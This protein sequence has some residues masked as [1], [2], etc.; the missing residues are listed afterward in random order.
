MLNHR[1]LKGIFRYYEFIAPVIPLDQ[2]IYL[3]EGHTPLVE[4]N[5]RLK[6]KLG[7]RL[8]NPEAHAFKRFLAAY[9]QA[10][11][12]SLYGADS[13]RL[14]KS[15]FAVVV[16]GRLSTDNPVV[17]FNLANMMVTNKGA[18]L[19]FHPTGDRHM[20]GLHKNIL[21][22]RHDAG[23]EEAVLY[24]ILD[25]FADR[26]A[27]PEETARYLD[28]Y[29]ATKQESIEETITESV[30]KED[31]TEE[32]VQKKITKEVEVKLSRLC[33]EFGV[34]FTRETRESIDKLLA[35]KETYTLVAGSDLFA[36]PRWENIAHLLGMIARL[37]PFEVLLLPDSV[38]TLGTAL[39]CDLD[40]EPTGSVA[41]YNA[42]GDFTLSALGGGDLDMPALNQQEGTV[43]SLD[44]RVVP[45]AP[46]LGYE[47]YTLGELADA[48]GVPV[49]WTVD[50]TVELPIDRGF[51]PVAFDTL[52]NHFGPDGENHRGY[53]LEEREGTAAGAVEPIGTTAPLR[54]GVYVANP[55]DQFNG[56][57]AK[58]PLI[59]QAPRL[60]LSAE[61]MEKLSLGENE[62]VTVQTD[63]GQRQMQ[64]A[65]YPQ[66]EGEFALLPDFDG[67]ETLYTRGEYRFLDATITKG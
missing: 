17:R 42:P 27:L 22:I 11:G 2:I 37:T 47:G 43:T 41:G 57:T 6:E 63:R 44:K 30:T 50:F 35:K 33:E 4:A 45:L 21:P 32:K 62:S 14:R 20:E 61:L 12:K 51:K 54:K 15:D 31:G 40:T 56:F 1:A 13:E 66:L 10:A 29:V 7:L 60:L 19:F 24:W 46:V 39:I 26:A 16:G 53:R 58:S 65:L 5:T 9:A 38:N 18:A 36:H 34:H 48:L 64:A 25:R 8:Y 67:D 52:S 28:G 59:A 55:L 3:G 23:R 49:R